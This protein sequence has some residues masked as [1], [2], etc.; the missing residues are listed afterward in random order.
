MKKN[1]VAVLLGLFV[2]SA[3]GQS[4]LLNERDGFK[5]IKLGS[6]KSSF[7]NLTYFNDFGEG[8]IWYTYNTPD[9]DLY[10]VFDSKYDAIHLVFDKNSEQLV[11][12]RLVKLYNDDLYGNEFYDK[13]LDQLSITSDKFAR[14]FGKADMMIDEPKVNSKLGL[15]WH[16]SKIYIAVFSLYFGISEGRAETIV[17][18]GNTTKLSDGF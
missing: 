4:T 8:Y 12:I 9:E 17:E 3:F 10:F 1:I 13:C 6:K 11:L 18:I 7:T 15:A 16:G 2:F 5:T 14:L